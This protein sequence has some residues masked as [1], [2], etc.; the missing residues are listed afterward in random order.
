[1]SDQKISE[2]RQRAQTAAAVA[3]P[4]P[5][6]LLE[7][8]RA[9]RRRRQ[10]V[11][12]AALAACAA[13]GIGFLGS[14]GGNPRTDQPPAN[15]P[16]VT[17]TPDPGPTPLADAQGPGTYT[18]DTMDDG[19]RPDATVELVG[20]GWQNWSAGA[21]IANAQVSWGFKMYEDTP[22]DQ[23]HE[24]RHAAS[25]S[26]AVAQLSHIEGTVTR[27]ARPVTRLGL[28]GTYLQLSVPVTVDCP[29][30]DAS[31]GNLMVIWPGSTDPT[32]TVDVWLLEDGDRLLILTRGV[33]GNPS[34]A[35]LRNLDRTLDS[36]QYVPAP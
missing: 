9:L 1:M 5:Y 12:V 27:A 36:L 8:G 13:I 4:D 23:C 21:V 10:L 17:E 20:D 19:G 28:T 14:V 34:P 32:V 11:P 33:R 15:R 7:R 2:F 6:L 24:N 31:G 3:A 29:N 22:I 35:T 18:L 16:S 26:G 25:M 30:G